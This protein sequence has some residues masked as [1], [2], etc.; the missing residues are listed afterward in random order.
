MKTTATSN[1]VKKLPGAKFDPFT[2]RLSRDIRNTLSESFMTA[3][4]RMDSS[5]YRN[6]ADIWRAKNLSDIYLE[7]IQDRLQRYDRVIEQIKANHLADPLL[8]SLV[9]WNNGLF[10]EFHDHLEGIWMQA[11]GDHR[12]ALK[13]MIKAAGVYVHHEFHHPAA[14]ESLS[15]KAFDLIRQ[16]SSSLAFIKN[17]DDLAQKLKTLDTEPPRL[18][19]P[20]LR[21]N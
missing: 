10:F 16:Y 14:V 21:E 9:I 12:Q 8:Q 18:E 1:S 11:T 15:A 4:S 7:Y 20:A 2:N 13:G 3:L 17:L 19:N 6:E 5:A